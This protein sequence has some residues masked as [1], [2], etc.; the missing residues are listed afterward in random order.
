M[1]STPK[2]KIFLAILLLTFSMSALAEDSAFPL[3]NKYTNVQTIST[4]E[5]NSR[6]D[7]VL[8][9]DVRSKLEYSVIHMKDALHIPVT[10]RDFEKKIAALAEQRPIVFYCNGIT[11]SKSYTAADRM[12]ASGYTNVLTYDAGIFAWVKAVPEKSYLLNET[13]VNPDK[14]ISSADFEDKNISYMEFKEAA[15]L[16]GAYIVDIRENYQRLENKSTK[17]GLKNV[18]VHKLP[19][20][21]FLSVVLKPGRLKDRQLLIVDAVGKQIRWLQY[22]LEQ[23]GYTNYQFLSGGIKAID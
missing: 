20:D 15:Q 21:K 2:L 18:K 7:A 14:I 19:T 17:L 10:R 12:L 3:R 22:Y 5:L 16:K 23:F 8:V 1:F 13:P 11:C 9:V 6:F 4:T